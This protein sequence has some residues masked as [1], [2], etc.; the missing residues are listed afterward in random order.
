MANTGLAEAYMMRRAL[1]DKMTMKKKKKSFEGSK[2]KPQPQNLDPLQYSEFYQ[3]SAT[4]RH[5]LCATET[6]LFCH[7]LQSSMVLILPLL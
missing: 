3:G 5:K 2:D 7:C 1:E 6:E 4:I